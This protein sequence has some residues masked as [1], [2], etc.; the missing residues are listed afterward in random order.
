MYIVRASDKGRVVE[1]ETRHS[2]GE[3]FNWG[4]SRNPAFDIAIE[5]VTAVFPQEARYALELDRDELLRVA[6]T[7]RGLGDS[8]ASEHIAALWN[9]LAQDAEESAAEC[10]RRA[11]EA[12]SRV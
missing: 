5:H 7:L 8:S 6:H 1:C 11:R 12:D 4:R 3:A 2:R 9:G 10:Q